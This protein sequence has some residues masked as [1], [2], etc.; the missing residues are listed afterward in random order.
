MDR[1]SRPEDL[2]GQPLPDLVLPD[3]AGVSFALRQR[4]GHGPL[5][6]FFIIRSGTP[7]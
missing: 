2:V 5:V 1:P 4:V 6:L 7:G 3:D